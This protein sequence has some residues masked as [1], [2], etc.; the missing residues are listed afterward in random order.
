MDWAGVRL[1]L[2]RACV[3]RAPRPQSGSQQTAQSH[4][5]NLVNPVYE[6]VRTSLAR[7]RPAS[8]GSVIEIHQT[9]LLSREGQSHSYGLESS[10]NCARVIGEGIH[11][12]NPNV[13]RT[14]KELRNCLPRHAE[15]RGIRKG[16]RSNTLG[17]HRRRLRRGTTFRALPRVYVFKSS[18][19]LQVRI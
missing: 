6:R 1:A 18:G 17:A 7:A 3:G 19:T 10:R 4:M 14:P 15:C 13:N 2:S 12:W 11:K 8:S 9:V 5:N 16:S